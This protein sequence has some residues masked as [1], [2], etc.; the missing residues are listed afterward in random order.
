MFTDKVPRIG[1]IGQY[2]I[3]SR[4]SNSKE[5]VLFFGSEYDTFLD[6]YTISRPTSLF[7][8]I[9]LLKLT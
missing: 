8:L 3:Q 5:A 4:F 7:L 6:N 2:H 9:I 1:T